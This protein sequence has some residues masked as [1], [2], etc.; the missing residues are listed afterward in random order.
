M[1]AVSFYW[2]VRYLPSEVISDVYNHVNA[3]ISNSDFQI[4]KPISVGRLVLYIL[5]VTMRLDDAYLN[6]YI[7][8]YFMPVFNCLFKN[9]HLLGFRT[10]GIELRKISEIIILNEF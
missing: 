10:P 6:N 2:H 8:E 1:K 3:N 4:E 7:Q 5:L 9:L